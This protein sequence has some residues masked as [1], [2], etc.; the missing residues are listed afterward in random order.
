MRH[1]AKQS[2]SASKP[3]RKRLANVSLLSVA[4][5]FREHYPEV[6]C[7]AETQCYHLA[8]IIDIVA[9][10]DPP[11]VLNA[12]RSFRRRR[13]IHAA[14]TKSVAELIEDLQEHAELFVSRLAGLRKLKKVLEQEEET[15]LGFRDPQIGERKGAE[16]HKAAH[17]IARYVETTLWAANAQTHTGKRMSRDK[18]GPFVLVVRDA[19][20]LAGQQERTADAIAAVLAKASN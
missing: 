4:E 12:D 14:M 13:E 20:V 9:N 15:F 5:L 8:N 7:P 3:K 18:H 11:P 17:L 2:R 10:R 19:L 16:W 1:T 6:Q